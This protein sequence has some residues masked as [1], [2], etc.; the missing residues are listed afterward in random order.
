MHDGGRAIKRFKNHLGAFWQGR[1][2]AVPQLQAVEVAIDLDAS[3]AVKVTQL[4]LVELAMLYAG[5]GGAI[6]DAF[7]REPG[8]YPADGYRNQN[9]GQ[10]P[11]RHQLPFKRCAEKG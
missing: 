9:A 10:N 6:S 3:G 11:H 7:G 4:G 5:T 1:A 2:A 8:T